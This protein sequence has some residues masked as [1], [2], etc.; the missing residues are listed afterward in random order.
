MG[1]WKRIT[2]TEKP[3]YLE[4]VWLYDEDNDEVVSG[5]R[6]AVGYHQLRDMAVAVN[7]THW[8][9]IEYPEKP[10]KQRKVYRRNS[11]AFTPTEGD[12]GLY[13]R[14]R[15]SVKWR[16]PDD[17]PHTL[18]NALRE[19]LDRYDLWEYEDE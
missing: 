11:A 8:M 9:E 10:A 6:G 1:K 16:A 3:G 17:F 14:A 12:V 19:L 18:A 5:W 4:D 13:V 2:E 7:A 15:P